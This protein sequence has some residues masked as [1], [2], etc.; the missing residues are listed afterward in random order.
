M[1]TYL[2]YAIAFAIATNSY[3]RIWETKAQC[4][5]RY[6]KPKIEQKAGS[7]INCVYSMKGIVISAM[8]FKTKLHPKAQKADDV[9]GMISYAKVNKNNL[10][11][12]KEMIKQR[13]KFID[14]IRYDVGRA[15]LKINFIEGLLKANSAGQQWQWL[16]PRKRLRE[17]QRLVEKKTYKEINWQRKGNPA[18]KATYFTIYP[19]NMLE[20]RTP[21]F[22]EFSWDSLKVTP[23]KKNKS[24]KKLEGF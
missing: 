20:F 13:R 23:K 14:I 7:Y 9:C 24:Q 17:W 16:K 1:K 5:K 18:A 22:Y 2:F 15:R 8:F 6:G 11:Y 3:A 10:A 19:H 21:A 12:K 4:E